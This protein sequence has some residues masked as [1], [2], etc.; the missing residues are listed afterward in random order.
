MVA[1]GR[2]AEVGC[3]DHGDGHED[4]EQ[5]EVTAEVGER[6]GEREELV[7]DRKVAD[8]EEGCA[9]HFDSLSEEVEDGD[10]NG[11][12][13]E[14]GDAAE[15]GGEGV[16]VVRFVE[17]HGLLILQ[18]GVLVFFFNSVD[19]RFELRLISQHFFV[20]FNGSMRKRKE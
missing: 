12:L 20:H 11:E 3:E 2:G 10:E 8:P 17:F 15:H 14:N 1:F 9:L 5:I 18:R 19:F 16:D 13:Q 6:E 4:G 7:G